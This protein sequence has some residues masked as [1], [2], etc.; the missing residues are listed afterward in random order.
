[1][2]ID[3]RR[4]DGFLANPSPARVV[5]FHG[6]DEG[7]IREYA[8]KLVRSVAGALDDPFRVSEVERDAYGTLPDE[9]AALSMTGG[10]RVVR[11]RDVTDGASAA[12]QKVLAGNGPGLLV[13][14]GPT[15]T[16]KS[17]LKTLVE[18]SDVAATVAC[19]PMDG[20]AITQLARSVLAEDRIRIDPDALGWL[21]G[22]LGAD[23]LVT[24]SELEKLALHAGPGGAVDMEVA[25]ACIGDL[26]G[27]SQ[28]DALFAATDG[29]VAGCDRALE[30]AMAEGAT[31]VGLLR[32]GLMHMQRF[33]RAR[34]L[35][36]GGA[37]AE[38]AVRVLRP[39]L[40]FK[41][42]PVFT[43]SLRL[44]NAGALELGTQRLS[45]TERACKRTGSPAETLCRNAL[46]GLAMRAAAVKR[47]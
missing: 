41:R 39:P 18:R 28:E 46:I 11:V 38:E 13:M 34:A 29:D 5:L 17:K 6:E 25:R 2:K 4:I 32:A 8:T 1:L 10:R 44:W 24:R 27:L 47:R 37:S 30:L 40:F 19:Y 43:R 22:Q 23:R 33:T 20:A 36:D 15:L 31:P 12:V 21:S 7:L 9:V 45:D 26:S 35:V 42:V 16:S 14:E 3:A